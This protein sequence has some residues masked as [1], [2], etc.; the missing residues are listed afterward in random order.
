MPRLLG[1]DDRPVGRRRRSEG[2][3]QPAAGDPLDYM[4]SVMADHSAAPGRR[5]GMAKAAAAYLRPKARA[6][7]ADGRELL[8]QAVAGAKASLARKLA[9]LAEALAARGG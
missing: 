1:E 5:D 7:T 2:N 9:R 6:G 4:L 8:D 3:P